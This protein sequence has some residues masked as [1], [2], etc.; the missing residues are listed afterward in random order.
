M[1]LTIKET[2]P[3]EPPT[4]SATRIAEMRLVDNL[5]NPTVLLVGK[6]TSSWTGHIL[7]KDDE[8]YTEWAYTMKL[9]LP[10]VQLWDY[11]FDPPTSPH[12]MYESRA[13][14]AWTSNKR[15]TCSFIKRAIFPSEQKLC[16]DMGD[17]VTLWT[18]LK[19]RHGGTVSVW[20]SK[21]HLL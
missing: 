3:D 16:E 5:S 21:R 15:L 9:K 1:S 20:F 18:Y 2:P 19:E 14:R 12:P 17:P 7:D 6:I 11:V 10:M 13:Y 4:S 8:K